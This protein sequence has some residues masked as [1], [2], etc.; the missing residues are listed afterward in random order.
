MCQRRG[1]VAAAEDQGR[2]LAAASIDVSIGEGDLTGVC[3]VGAV[4]AL[5]EGGAAALAAPERLPVPAVS[6][7]G[8]QKPKACWGHEE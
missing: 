3:V 1:A 8:L 2:A 4:L 7:K 6:R 5:P